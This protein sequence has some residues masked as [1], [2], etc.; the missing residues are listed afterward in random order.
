MAE[1]A[2]SCGEWMVVMEEELW[3]RSAE[4]A[5]SR[6]EGPGVDLG[7]AWRRQVPERLHAAV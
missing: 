1:A 4:S 3:V 6:A 2:A 7:D 5:Y